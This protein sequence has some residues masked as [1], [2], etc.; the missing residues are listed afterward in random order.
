[1]ITAVE[2]FSFCITFVSVV[3]VDV[4]VVVGGGGRCFLRFHVLTCLVIIGNLLI[5]M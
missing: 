4:V 3:V 5:L 2:Q 1:M